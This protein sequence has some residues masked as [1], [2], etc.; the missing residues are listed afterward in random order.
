MSPL[1]S[2]PE[3]AGSSPPAAGCRPA[4]LA[5]AE[6]MAE[7]EERVQAM[8]V[9]SRVPL[10]LR[11]R[12]AEEGVLRYWSLRGACWARRVGPSMVDLR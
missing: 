1:H 6:A 9:A 7:P 12:R 2:S 5:L 3:T 11:V 10:L 8:E 4:T